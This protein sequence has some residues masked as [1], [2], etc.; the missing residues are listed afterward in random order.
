MAEK[1][2]NT[3]IA[4]KIDSYTNWESST[5]VLKKGEIALATVT[6][7]ATYGQTEPVVMAKVGDGEHVFKDL[8]WNFY[9]KASDVLDACKDATKLTAFIENAVKNSSNIKD[10]TEFKNL[11]ARVSVAEGKITTLEGQA[12]TVDQRITEAV[13]AAIE[14]EVERAEAAYSK[15][16]HKHEIAD[17]NGLSDAIAD[18]KKA[19]TDAN[20]ALESYKTSNNAAVALKAAQADLEAE[21]SA[22]EQADIALGGR[23]DEVIEDVN[24]NTEAIAQEIA[25]RKAAITKEVEDRDAAIEAAIADEVTTRDAAIAVETAAREAAVAAEAKARQEAITG[26]VTARNEA[27]ATA[28]GN[29]VSRADGKYATITTA[30]SLQT[31]INT[32]MNNPDAEG[33]INSI[34]EFTQYVK[35]HGTIAKGM[36]DAIEANAGAIADEKSRAEGVEGGLDTRLKA[37]EDAIGGEGSVADAIEDAV[38]EAQGY[39]DEKVKALADG[40]VKANADAIAQEV[41]DRDAA[42]KAET[43]ARESAIS[44][45]AQAR[46]KGDEDTLAAAKSDAAQQISAAITGLNIGQYA[47]AADLTAEVG[48]REAADTAL[49]GRIDGVVGRVETLEGAKHTHANKAE[50]DKFV[51]GDKAKLDTAVQTVKANAGLTATKSGTEVTIGFDDSVTFVFNCGDASTVI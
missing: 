5:I 35:D 17:V 45:E 28:I 25:D 16:G 51:D 39:T 6:A 44:G 15:L 38:A 1:I 18:A 27:I 24:D 3:R 31:Q 10:N 13:T 41:K 20:S 7:D 23:I 2:L 43:A 49:G 22:R 47:K 4:L 19:G 33:A 40:A 11:V 46:A 21:T 26:E 37:V 50:L 42:V 9:A 29:E 8:E 34:N 32:I 48:A 30:E 14:A 36:Q 12:A